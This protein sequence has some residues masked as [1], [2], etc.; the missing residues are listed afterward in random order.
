MVSAQN[1]NTRLQKGKI[2]Y[3]ILTFTKELC[4]VCRFVL[5]DW[6]LPFIRSPVDRF[7]SPIPQNE[8]INE[9]NHFH[10][11]KA[12]VRGCLEVEIAKKLLIGP[13]LL[14]LER[15]RTNAGAVIGCRLVYTDPARLSAC[16][17]LQP[18]QGGA[19]PNLDRIGILRIRSRQTDR[20]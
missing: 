2:K 17:M 6:R 14:Q 18:R 10:L 13:R 8:P 3:F 12:E 7:W 15:P 20:T 5:M 11:E 9:G 19:K 16:V 4:D 1:C